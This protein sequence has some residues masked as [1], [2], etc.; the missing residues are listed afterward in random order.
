MISLIYKWGLYIINI[1]PLVI[2]FSVHRRSFIV[3]SIKSS[4]WYLVLVLNAIFLI[5]IFIGDLSVSVSCFFIIFDT[6]Y[7]TSGNSNLQFIVGTD[8]LNLLLLYA[9]LSN[10][11]NFLSAKLRFSLSELKIFYFT[12][13]KLY[14]F[15]L[16]FFSNFFASVQRI[17]NNNF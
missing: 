1:L 13:L 15:V 9:S 14:P 11:L 12:T 2:L 3:S 5:H 16:L 4:W 8:F 6:E 7:N 17:N 10:S